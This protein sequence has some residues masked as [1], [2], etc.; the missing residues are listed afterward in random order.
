M[1]ENWVYVL[2]KKLFIAIIKDS[3]LFFGVHIKLR[4]DKQGFFTRGVFE[5]GTLYICFY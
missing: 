5:M 4:G 3:D 2:I 1:E